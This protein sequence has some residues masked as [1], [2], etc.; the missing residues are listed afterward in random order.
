MRQGAALSGD[1]ARPLDGE[2]CVELAFDHFEH[3]RDAHVLCVMP[4]QPPA[5]VAGL[6][7]PPAASRIPSAMSPKE[8]PPPFRKLSAHIK[9]FRPHVTVMRKVARPGP[10]GEHSAV[11]WLSELAL[12]ESRTLPEGALYSVVE[13]YALCGEQNAA[14]SSE[15]P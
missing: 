1:D 5:W 13:S 15:T 14:N 3:W 2:L 9:I 7:V 12:I 10:M 11:G 8:A 6:R 4:A